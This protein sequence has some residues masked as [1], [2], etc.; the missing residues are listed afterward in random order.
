MSGQSIVLLRNSL[1]LRSG[2]CA[3]YEV[4]RAEESDADKYLENALSS[5]GT[6]GHRAHTTFWNSLSQASV[7]EVSCVCVQDFRPNSPSPKPAPKYFVYRLLRSVLAVKDEFYHRHI[8]QYNLFTPVFDL[9]RERSH[10][11]GNDL[12]SSAILE[13]RLAFKAELYEVTAQYLTLFLLSFV[14][15]STYIKDVRFHLPRKH[16]IS[17]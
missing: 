1:F 3:S 4:F 9:L 5:R 8:I 6:V 7:V 12:L 17:N 2:T 14:Y 15:F 11:V 10:S 16:Q 13:V